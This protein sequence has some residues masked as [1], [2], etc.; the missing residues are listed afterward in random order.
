MSIAY[1]IKYA[2]YELNNGDLHQGRGV[3]SGQI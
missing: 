2:L 3:V 1:M